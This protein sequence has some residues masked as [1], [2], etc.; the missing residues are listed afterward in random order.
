VPLDRSLLKEVEKARKYRE[1]FKPSS[2]QI[3]HWH[4]AGETAG[5]HVL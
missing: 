2:T 3:L 1:H 5:I 4:R